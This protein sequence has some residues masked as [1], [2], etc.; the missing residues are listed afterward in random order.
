MPLNNVLANRNNSMFKDTI[1]L[2]MVSVQKREGWLNL[3]IF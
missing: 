2:P 1:L 3:S